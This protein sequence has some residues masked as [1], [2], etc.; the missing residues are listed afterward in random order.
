MLYALDPLDRLVTATPHMTAPELLAALGPAPDFADAPCVGRWALFDPPADH[1]PAASVSYR[2]EAAGR[3]CATCP[4]PTFARCAAT[5]RA[6]PK[7]GRRGV[8][9]GHSYDTLKE[10]R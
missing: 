5:V 7:S 3:V 1:E 10:T 9:A 8:W 2:H 4:L 6:L